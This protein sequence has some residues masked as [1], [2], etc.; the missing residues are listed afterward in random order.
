MVLTQLTIYETEWCCKRASLMEIQLFDEPTTVSLLDNP[1][2]RDK[3]TTL[4]ENQK[5]QCRLLEGVSVG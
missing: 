2:H 1:R 5:T 3:T 4:S